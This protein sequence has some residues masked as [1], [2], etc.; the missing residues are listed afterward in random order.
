MP[1]DTS[2]ALGAQA[3]QV[4]SFNPMS[5]YTAAQ[6]QQL[7]ALR[8]RALQEE[9]ARNAL[10]MQNTMED[11]RIAAAARAQAAAAAAEER[12]R[13]GEYRGVVG[14]FGLTDRAIGAGPGLKYNNSNLSADPY[15]PIQNELLRRGFV[16][17]AEELAKLQKE[18]LAGEESK[19]KIPGL[20]AESRKKGTE[21]DT[22]EYDA[23]VS[24]L[25]P[26]VRSVKNGQDAA[27]FTNAMYD[28]PT[29]GPK[30]E[31][32]IPR[33]QAVARAPAEYD[34]NPLAWTQS[35]M[36]TGKE[37]SDALSAAQ[38]P[39]EMDLGGKKVFVDPVTLQPKAEFAKTLTPDEANKSGKTKDAKASL[40]DTLARLDEEYS[41][42]SDLGA[43]PTEKDSVLGNLGRKFTSSYIGQTLGVNP[44]A[45]T[46]I[47]AIEGLRNDVLLAIKAASG[48]SAKEMDS[49]AE[50]QRQ[51]AGATAPGQNI[52]SVRRRLTD[53][54]KKYGAGKDY[55]KAEEK[56]VKNTTAK[57]PATNSKGWT[58][59]TDANGNR[60]YVSPD[61]TQFE[62]VK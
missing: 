61:G 1:L 38:K 19:A 46:H 11:R 58:L 51:L 39:I 52:E 16:P 37:L 45:Q 3:P 27:N 25:V 20:Q 13:L 56:S 23:A 14:N 15:A 55:T 47:Q 24:R 17:Q 60:A 34:A 32:I 59:H 10:T 50:L 44:Q 35:H 7:N 29:L 9:M 31:K 41:A 62:E 12:R 28:D 4:Q 40:E 57:A 48:M 43:Q 2:I 26:L 6:D 21:A 33:A 18:Q 54:S 8:A 36:L 53:L 42:L 5:I 30:L 22:A 49:N